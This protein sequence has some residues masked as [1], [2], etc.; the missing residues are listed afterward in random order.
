MVSV[1]GIRGRIG[2]AMTPDVAVAAAAAFGAFLVEQGGGRSPRV[3]LGRDSRTSGPMLVRAV[4]AALESVGCE[5]LDVG[6]V[7]TPTALLSIGYHRAD[8]AVVVTASHNPV[9]WNALKFASRNGMF[10]DA[11]EGALMQSFLPPAGRSVPWAAWDELGGV[12]SDEGAVQRHIEAI[13][14]IPFL[15]VDALR[16]RGFRVFLDCVR[17][18]GGV[19][20]PTLL[21]ELGCT[22]I[23]ANL[24]PDGLF[25]REPE[26]VPH[27]LAEV[28]V[29]A[30]SAAADIG[31]VL[32]PDGDRLAI[33]SETGRPVGEDMTLAFATALVLRHIN[34]PVVT[35]LSTSRILDDVAGR[36][37]APLF[38][39]PVGEINVASRMKAEDAVI[40]GEGNGGVILPAVHLTRDAG[41]AAALALQLLLE[42]DS[43]VE[44]LVAE[45]PVYSIIKD[46]LPRSAVD[47][48]LVPDLVQERLGEARIDRQDGIRLDW[49]ERGIWL[50]LRPS[51]TEPILRVIAEASHESEARE[52]IREV[53][54]ALD[55]AEG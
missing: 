20:L 26:P 28:E 53:Y 9:E 36:A 33:L 38:R 55:S 25:P 22:V 35:N 6:L 7:P 42:T 48:D 50:H 44:Q 11:E 37:G 27:N 32:D 4:T 41:V 30:R 1:S 34:G 54:R 47:L 39:A 43:S 17:G 2:E 24:E 51:G 8:G 15:D 31:M 40:G 23:G 52:L 29:E 3:I 10:L 46:K 13:L 45:L 14:G 19:L 21:Q 49:D 12:M 16:G 5:I 18:A